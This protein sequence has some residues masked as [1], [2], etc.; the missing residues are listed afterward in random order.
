MTSSKKPPLDNLKDSIRALSQK[1][2]AIHIT[3][4]RFPNFRNLRQDA[5][6]PFD[7]PITVILGK[8]GTNKSSILHALYGAPKGKTVADFWFETK[9]DAIPETRN[10][11]KQS[12]VHTYRQANGTLTDCIKARAPRQEKDPDYWEAV[13]PTQAYGFPPGAKRSSPI[14]ISVLHLDFRGELPA[15]DKYFYFPDQSHLKERA[16]AAKNSS[17]LRREYRK[18]DYLRRRSS[19]LKQQI[20]D[21]GTDLTKDEIQILNHILEQSYTA[22]KIFE[23]NLFHGHVGSTIVFQT[24]SFP[25]YSEAFAGSGE[26]AA[27]LLVHKVLSAQK[28]SLIL[29]DEPET[30]LHPGAQQRLLEFLAHYAVRKSLQIVMATHSIYLAK[31]LP[32]EAIRVLERD[33]NGLIDITTSYSASEALHE[34]GLFPPGKVILVEDERAKTILVDALSRSS[35]KAKKDIHVIVRPGGTS[36]I[37]KDVQAYA[38]VDKG[39]VF[40]FL[41][42]DHRPTISIPLKGELPQGKK[43]LGD[44]ILELTKGNNL[45]GP[46]L[47]FVDT[48]EMNLYIE[49]M[50]K[51]MFF[52]PKETPE[53]LVWSDAI[54]KDLLAKDVPSSISQLPTFKDRIRQLAEELHSSQDF[55]FLTMLYK[56]L[57]EDNPDKAQLMND[58][59]L[60][61][62]S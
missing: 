3:K 25:G 60:I 19:L 46:E 50:R 42:G 59:K 21:N 40:F 1:K 51:S 4:L 44:L 47:S 2:D 31:G 6:L 20:A 53:E 58:L 35:S 16:K 56:F 54:A 43:E 12:V 11:L 57:S 32:Q 30:S 5:I 8:N 29:L 36:R 45:Q 61:R 18:Q 34:I 33:A 10:D 28:N 17:K 37:F 49:F 27:T 23:H 26:S 38:R 24:A 52:L 39:D 62:E 22:G 41:D 14:D 9:L 15:F 13:K 7:F 55:V 48:S